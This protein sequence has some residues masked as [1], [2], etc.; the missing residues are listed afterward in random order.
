MPT[1]KKTDYAKSTKTA[2][3]AASRELQTLEPL[4]K[5][6]I[7][8][9]GLDGWVG[10]S[11]PR[12]ELVA[13]TI[14]GTIRWAKSLGKPQAPTLAA[15]FKIEHVHHQVAID[16]RPGHLRLIDLVAPHPEPIKWDGPEDEAFFRGSF[17][18]TALEG[19]QTRISVRFADHIRWPARIHVLGHTYLDIVPA[20]QRFA[21]PKSRLVLTPFE[22]VAKPYSRVVG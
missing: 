3:Q 1:R 18:A 11:T 15:A 13:D 8:K 6:P 12:A 10:G 4:L 14:W 21:K 9:L 16:P 22:V 19:Q 20:E 5:L 17:A 7:T 2:L